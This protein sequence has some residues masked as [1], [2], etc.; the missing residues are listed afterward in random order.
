MEGLVLHDPPL[1]LP[2]A[3]ELDPDRLGDGR[4]GRYVRGKGKVERP[5][6]RIKDLRRGESEYLV[7]TADAEGLLHEDYLLITR[8][9][10]FL[11][12]DGPARGQ[13][14]VSFGGAHGTGTRAV[15][16]LLK[17]P[18]LLGKVL[19]RLREKQSKST[20][21]LGGRPDAYQLLFRTSDIEH[22]AKGSIPRALELVDAT[23]LPDNDAIWDHAHRLVRPRL[24]RWAPDSRELA[25]AD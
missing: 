20:G 25:S 8:V 10:N 18:V 19:E 23:I 15:A 6:W 2:Y 5:L 17:D 9:R 4:V 3:W 11:S 12:D 16:L 22:S 24:K 13:F 21:R 7:P 1:D 14:L